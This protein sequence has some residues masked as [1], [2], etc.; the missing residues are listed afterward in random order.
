MDCIQVMK[1]GNGRLYPTGSDQY[2]RK[3]M[4]I[5]DEKD[6]FN[7]ICLNFNEEEF[8]AYGSTASDAKAADRKAKNLQSAAAAKK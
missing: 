6:C 8:R 5:C 1:K 4:D 7:Y 2:V 3:L